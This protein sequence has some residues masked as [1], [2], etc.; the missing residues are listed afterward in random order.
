MTDKKNVVIFGLSSMKE[1]AENVSKKV[2]IKLGDYELQK[3]MDGEISFKTETSV[4]GKIVFVFQTISNPT[5]DN[6]MELLIFIDMLKR[7]SANE[8]NVVIPYLGYSRQDKKD[9][10]RQPITASLVS[11]LIEVAGADR[12][13]SYDLH[14]SQIQ[15]FFKIPVDELKTWGIFSKKISHDLGNDNLMVVSPDHGGIKRARQVSQLLNS[16]LSVIYKRRSKPNEIEEMKLLGDVENKK[17]IVIDD[18]IDTGG[19]IVNS[20]KLLKEKKAKEIYVVATHGILSSIEN[21]PNIVLN[22]IFNAGAKGI[23]LSNTVNFFDKLTEENKNRV[24][25][26]DITESLAGI[27]LAHV[28]NDSITDFF[29]EEYNTI[30]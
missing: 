9:S 8:I 29:I 1:I 27:I 3:F 23:Y 5:N 30:L 10:G 24:F 26:I 14:S 6:L 25:K 15:G 13:I 7:S 22:K 11:S 16:P 12:V 20:V 2:K 21:D 28:K 4:R 18:M 17:C 19:T